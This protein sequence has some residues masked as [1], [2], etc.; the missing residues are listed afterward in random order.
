MNAIESLN[1]LID[2]KLE[3]IS[4]IKLVL[5]S[6]AKSPD[7]AYLKNVKLEKVKEA[8]EQLSEY[9]AKICNVYKE[10]GFI[11]PSFMESLK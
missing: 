3:E 9:I 10:Y 1:Q 4:E 6:A 5:N 11:P 8:A 7:E 2:K